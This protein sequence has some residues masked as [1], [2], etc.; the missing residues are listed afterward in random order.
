[1][2]MRFQLKTLY[3]ASRV[4]S[5]KCPN[6]HAVV[7]LAARCMTKLPAFYVCH[8]CGFIGEIGVG[9]VRDGRS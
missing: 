5:T 2:G 7:M 4:T 9:V 8:A 6:G 1:M 3:R